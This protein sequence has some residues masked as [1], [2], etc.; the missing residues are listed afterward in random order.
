M[1][2]F[3]SKV[4]KFYLSL[5]DDDKAEDK[6]CAKFSITSETLNYILMSDLVENGL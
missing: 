6:T 4:V 5:S 1:D 3:E 2:D